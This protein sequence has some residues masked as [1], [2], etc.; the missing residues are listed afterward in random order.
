MGN[1]K[2]RRLRRVEPQ[3]PGGEKNLSET[4][5]VQGIA[6]STNVSENA[7]NV[8]D[9][10]IGSEVTKLSQVSKEIEIISQRSTE[11]NNTK[12]SQIE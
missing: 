3:S 10:N 2:N 6:T 11:R 7:D 8:F 12:L 1:K 9:R 4:S 5:I